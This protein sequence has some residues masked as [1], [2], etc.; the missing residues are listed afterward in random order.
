MS[1]NPTPAAEYVAA[2]R[3]YLAT[4]GEESLSRAY[5]LGRRV[6]E[7]GVHELATLHHQALAATAGDSD[8]AVRLWLGR[9]AEFF[10]E[11]VSP[12]EMALS[13][14]RTTTSA[15]RDLNAELERRND[16][17]GREK[18]AVE[19]AN[20]E[21]EAFSYTV[22]HDLRAPLRSIDGFSRIL[23]E[24]CEPK[25]DDADKRYLARVRQSARDMQQLIE[26][27]LK[28]SRVSR[29]EM[30]LERVSL[31]SLV[32]ASIDRLQ[33]ADP[34]RSVTVD[35]ASDL[36]VYG[37]RRLLGVV[38]ENLLGNAWKFTGKR[39]DAR[40]TVG[41]T[42][43]DPP[44]Y[45]VRDNGAGFD[46]AYAD[47]LFE[48]FQRLHSSAD[49]AGTGI[50]LATVRRIVERHGGRIWAEGAVD[51]GAT[52]FLTLPLKPAE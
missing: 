12:L 4:G 42:D 10:A 16:E 1:S 30:N 33:D 52:F 47:K 6:V 7:G 36:E 13:G 24:E 23:L 9:A 44:V 48:V 43:D 45:F 31:G 20:M 34:D 41:R 5:D 46:P 29:G 2:L 27:L 21:L 40:I 8:T 14:Y 38:L 22:A 25:L 39:A 3:D 35:V 32:Q 51:R 18:Q 49:F 28:L 11:V 17:L 15:L 37:D 26:D 50:G 19:A